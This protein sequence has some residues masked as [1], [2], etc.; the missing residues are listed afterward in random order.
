[1]PV[2]WILVVGALLYLGLRKLEQHHSLNKEKE[3]TEKPVALEP[4]EVSAPA[5]TKPA[6]DNDAGEIPFLDTI[7]GLPNET[8]TELQQ[9]D[10]TT[11][12]AIKNTPDKDL[13]GIKG[14]GPARLKQIRTLCADAMD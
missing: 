6:T 12:K 1:M 4:E 7:A 13:M 10:L 5:D 2:I 14:I 11:P 9:L 8:K 3:Q